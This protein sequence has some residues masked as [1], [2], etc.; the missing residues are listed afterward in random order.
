MYYRRQRSFGLDPLLII[1]IATVAFYFVS[2][3]APQL[4]TSLG[5]QPA[6]FLE[7][8]WT[9]LTH[10]FLH[11]GLFHLLANMLALFFF[12]NYLSRLIGNRDFLTIYFGGGLMGG[13]VYVLLG[14]LGNPLII[15]IGASGA[16]FALGGTLTILQ[17]NIRVFIFPIPVPMPLWVAVIGGFFLLSLFPN[18]A[19]QGHLGGLLF[20]LGAG[21]LIKNRR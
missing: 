5:L 19:W 14:Q 21:Y 20:G 2:I 10:M 9:L 1:I 11:G 3:S 18:V 16:V 7:K 12:G 13:L 6:T 8:P 4:I 17:P 15:A